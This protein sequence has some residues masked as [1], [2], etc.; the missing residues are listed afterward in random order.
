[1]GGE[2]DATGDSGQGMGDKLGV[3]GLYHFLTLF[4]D[5]GWV[6]FTSTS[7]GFSPAHG[8]NNS[9][10]TRILRKCIEESGVCPANTQH[11][12][13]GALDSSKGR[14]SNIWS[15]EQ[16]L[17]PPQESGCE[18]NPSVGSGTQECLPAR[19]V[20][21][22]HMV[23]YEWRG[24]AL[25]GLGEVVS[26]QRMREHDHVWQRGPAFQL[27]EHLARP[28]PLA[29]E[30]RPR[31]HFTETRQ[32]QALGP[33]LSWGLRAPGMSWQGGRAGGAALCWRCSGRRAAGWKLGGPAQPSSPH[34]WPPAWGIQAREGCGCPA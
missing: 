29:E 15:Q 28:S 25:R 7:L 4:C 5:P 12:M 16:K 34:V 19:L 8:P 18:E 1:M 33:R 2:R 22:F 32:L 10:C 31:A 30:G 24:Q 11:G 3:C 13:S 9:F 26:R 20:L 17:R 27:S 23:A 14:D 6:I 21:P